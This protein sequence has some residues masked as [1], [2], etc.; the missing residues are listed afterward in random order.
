M[1]AWKKSL[2]KEAA[3]LST[4]VSN[5]NNHQNQMGAYQKEF[6][7]LS[8][9]DSHSI[10]LETGPTFLKYPGNSDERSCRSTLY[11]NRADTL[12]IIRNLRLVTVHLLHSDHCHL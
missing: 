9:R 2:Y 10:G 5:I 6:L 8:T 3:E 11:L 1:T 7:S 12:T 4:G